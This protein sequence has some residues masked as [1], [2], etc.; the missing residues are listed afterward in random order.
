MSGSWTD[1]ENSNAICYNMYNGAEWTAS[2]IETDF[3]VQ[4]TPHT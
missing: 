3:W 1:Q 4:Q 2:V